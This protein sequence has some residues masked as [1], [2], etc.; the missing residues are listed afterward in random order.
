MG[1]LPT[2]V[3]DGS[4][5]RQIPNAILTDE[6]PNYLDSQDDPADTFDPQNDALDFFET[7]EG[8]RVTIP[9]MVVGDGFVSGSDN[10][11]RFKAYSTVHADADQ[12]NSRGGYTIAGDPA[13]S[14]PDTPN[15]GDDSTRP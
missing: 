10:A 5:G 4:A 14:G 1:T 3:L 6:V 8:M 15:S 13:L 9:D 12:I 11:V 2:Y 7:V